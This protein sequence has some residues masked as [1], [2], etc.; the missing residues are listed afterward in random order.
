MACI[1]ILSN[2]YQERD[3][4]ERTQRPYTGERNTLPK[5]ID[6]PKQPT[7]YNFGKFT[8]KILGRNVAEDD[9][10]MQTVVKEQSGEK[11]MTGDIEKTF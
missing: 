5:P 2:V 6:A 7:E 9:I 8:E 10:D 4:K 3:R 11:E 1:G